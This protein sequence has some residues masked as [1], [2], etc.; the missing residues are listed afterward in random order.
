MFSKNSLY[1]CVVAIALTT[2][3]LAF[4]QDDQIRSVQVRVDDL[5]LNSES[6]KAVLTARVEQATGKLCG[7]MAQQRDLIVREQVANCRSEALA[8]AQA[9]MQKAIAA[10]GENAKIAITLNTDR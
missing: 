6:G 4:A 3:V 2:P 10:A 8:S 9:Q 7:T 1:S 5:N